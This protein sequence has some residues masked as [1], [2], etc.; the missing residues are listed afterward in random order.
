VICSQCKKHYESELPRSESKRITGICPEC[1]KALK[2]DGLLEGYAAICGIICLMT[3]LLFVL[4]FNIKALVFTAVA[5]CLVFFLL[6]WSIL[7]QGYVYPVA[8][9]ESVSPN[10]AHR[11]MGAAIAVPVLIIVFGLVFEF[12]V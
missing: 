3:P 9:K 4:A 6:R 7:R 12:I 10:W 5:L 1:G 11:L 8:P 2:W